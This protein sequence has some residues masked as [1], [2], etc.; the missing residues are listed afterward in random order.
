MIYIGTD[1]VVQ[2][3]RTKYV[4]IVFQ[5]PEGRLDKTIKYM[6]HMT[7]SERLHVEAALT[8]DK[9]AELGYPEP[10]ELHFDY[11]TNPKHK[12]YKH[13]LAYRGQPHAKFKPNSW[14]A[15][16]VADYFANH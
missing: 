13:Y 2:K 14:I 3:D 7:N 11:N 9:W 6:P 1:S 8:L 16:H 15:S 12:S 10:C 5:L 4:T